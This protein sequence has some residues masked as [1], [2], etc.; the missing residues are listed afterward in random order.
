ML[1]RNCTVE[2]SVNETLFKPLSLAYRL[3]Y[4]LSRRVHCG[5]GVRLGSG[6]GRGIA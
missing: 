1:R 6:R 5:E 3:L 2:M 4:I